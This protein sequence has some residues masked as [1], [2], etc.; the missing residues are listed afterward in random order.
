[1]SE[2]LKGF[3]ARLLKART[4]Y[5]ERIKPKFASLK[6]IFDSSRFLAENI[7]RQLPDVQKARSQYDA[8]LEDFDEINITDMTMESFIV[9]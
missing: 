4:L 3:E 7:T 5:E 1:M 9:I 2:M 8:A 6:Q